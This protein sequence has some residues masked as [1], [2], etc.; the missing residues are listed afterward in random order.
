[1]LTRRRAA[2][3]VD[4]AGSARSSR[5]RSGSR[6]SPMTRCCWSRRGAP[7]ARTGSPAR[8]SSCAARRRGRAG[9]R[10]AERRP[11]SRGGGSDLAARLAARPRGRRRRCRTGRSTPRRWSTADRSAGDPT[12]RRGTAGPA[13]RSAP[14]RAGRRARRRP[15]PAR[16]WSDAARRRGRRARSRLLTAS[17]PG[18]VH[19]DRHGRRARLLRRRRGRGALAPG[20]RAIG[21]RAEPGADL[22]GGRGAARRRRQRRRG[23]DRRGPGGARAASRRPD[24]VD[25]HA[26][27]HRDGGPRRVRHGLR[28]RV[29]VRVRGR[30]SAA[31]SSACCVPS[32]PP[33]PG[34]ADDARRGA[35]GR[36]GAGVAGALVGAAVA[37]AL[38]RA[39]GRRRVRA[40]RTSRSGSRLAA[41]RLAFVVGPVVALLGV[42]V[43]GPARRP[44]PAAGGAARGGGGAAADERCGGLGG[45]VL[46]RWRRL[47][48]RGTATRAPTSRRLRA[49]QRDGADRGLTVLAPAVVRP[50]ACAVLAAGPLAARSACW[51]GTA[52]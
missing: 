32:A 7:G 37:P 43:G 26:G 14:Y 15:R 42:V 2:G 3:P 21:L 24:P 38:G 27:A 28:G 4:R 12:T 48:R 8:R 31:A 18:A 30:R 17:G 6:W 10:F 36:R 35:G 51:S 25:R 5:S 39:A 40:G 13:P 9:D 22:G 29:D 33:P 19:G 46:R 20:V 41:R 50:V 47:L 52:R 44:G 45:I 1:M 49:V 23:A 34:P 11:W 16:S